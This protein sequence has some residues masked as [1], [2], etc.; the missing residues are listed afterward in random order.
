MSEY[1]ATV[2]MEQGGDRLVNENISKTTAASTG[3]A[4]HGVTVLQSSAAITVNMNQPNRVGI[5]KRIVALTTWV[6]KVRTNPAFINNSTCNQLQ[7]S[8]SSKFKWKGTTI[9]LVSYSTVKW[10]ATIVAPSTVG[11]AIVLSTNA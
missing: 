3:V 7:I 5:S 10:Y 2:F 11:Q 9:D 1:N 8:N 4:N 6:Y